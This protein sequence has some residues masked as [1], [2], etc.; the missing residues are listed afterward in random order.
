M[1]SSEGC[2]AGAA[3]RAHDPIRT[4]GPT[5]REREGL[6]RI[7]AGR[8]GRE[9]A[10]PRFVARTTASQHVPAVLAKPGDG[11]RTVVVGVVLRGRSL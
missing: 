9:I 11:S 8:F 6:R 7:A 10:K 1:A 4:P 2:R 5:R 3:H